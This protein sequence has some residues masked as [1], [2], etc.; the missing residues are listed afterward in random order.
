M[1]CHV[2]KLHNTP[3][4][5]QDMLDNL[6]KTQRNRLKL[7]EL[8]FDVITTPVFDD[9]NQRLG[10]VL[11][12][13]DITQELARSQEERRIADENLRIRQA[14]DTVATNTLIA[15][16]NNNIIYLNN[17]FKT[18]MAGAQ[19]DI[20]TVMPDFDSRKLL[21]TNMDAF[22]K[23]PTHQQNLLNKLSTTL[24][25][26]I[27]IGKRMFA[28]ISN[29]I[30]SSEGSRIGTVVEWC[31][32]TEENGIEGEIA[33]L[34]LA[35][36]AGDLSI[37][38][39][40]I[41]KDG[42][43][44]IL[45]QGL[46]SLISIADG[47]ISETVHMLD[48][49]AHGDLTQRIETDYRGSFDK[50]KHDSNATADKLTEVI[51]NITFSANSVTSGSS[52]IAQGNA[53]LGQRTE[54]QASA[55]EE[56]AASM[57][58][59]TATVKLNATNADTAKMLSQQAT[60][61]AKQGGEVVSMAV[62]AMLKINESSKK[63]TDII[64]VIDEIAFQTNLLALNAAVEAARAGEHGRGFAVVASEVR[65]LAQRSASAAKEIKTLIK[66]SVT[67]VNDGS[68]LVNESG[69]TLK[70][71]VSAI[72]KVTKMV[73]DISEASNEQSDGINQVNKAITQIDGMTQQNA[74]LVEE[75]TAA[76]ESVVEQANSMKK[77]LSFFTVDEVR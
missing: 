20:Q 65:N 38:I 4:K 48:A 29:P 19:Q 40:E 68:L 77:M 46:N 10:T 45:A 15:D 59:I 13:N 33:K 50:L 34:I 21:G 73:E 32:R 26:E 47:V 67:K 44:L 14:L 72:G 60:D 27:T 35:A 74:A 52:E 62:D 75:A 56:T 39:E 70:E 42:F 18:M 66:D 53:E 28:L 12:W 76:G 30:L 8:T 7:A 61:T 6:D 36:G 23:N 41:G 11:E 16:K 54:A 37:R 43:F 31:D 1:G 58:T 51:G 69:D 55:L 49:V 9:D 24:K 25:A 2:Y 3:N 71:I 5:Q 64:G 22:H 57:E 63:V 17:S